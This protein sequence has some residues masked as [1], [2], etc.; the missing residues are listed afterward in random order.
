[1]K[2]AYGGVIFDEYGRVLLREPRSHYGGYVWTFPKGGPDNGESPEE[3]ALRE[4]REEAGVKASI[5]CRIPGTF[6]GDTTENIFYLMKPIEMASF[7]PDETIN[8]RWATYEEATA[9]I[10]QSTTRSGKARDLAV[11]DA[12]F[13]AL[14]VMSAPKETPESLFGLLRAPLQPL[15]RATHEILCK[16]H[17]GCSPKVCA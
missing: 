7:E 10:S 16:L 9:L 3:T 17:P 1:M 8:I 13:A 6:K 12:A 5:I 2:T 14:K 15:A 11:L 4:V